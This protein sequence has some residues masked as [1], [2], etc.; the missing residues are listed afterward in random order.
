MKK[1]LSSIL[2]AV[3]TAGALLAQNYRSSDAAPYQPRDTWPY[4]YADFTSGVI[5]TT[6][7]AST[8]EGTFNVS[9]IDGSLHYIL[10]GTIMKLDMASVLTA[11]IGEELY[12]NIGNKMYRVLVEKEN[13]WLLQYEQVDMEEMNKASIGYGISSS[14]ASTQNVSTLLE[15]SSDM[16]NMLLENAISAKANG[17]VLPIAKSH[18]IYCGG[19][20]VAAARSSIREYPLI[21]KKEA[22]AF[23]KSHKIKWNKPESLE[24]LIDFVASQINKK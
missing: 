5:R 16:V 7:N 19:Y 3:L 11:K 2:L 23:L 9:L 10:N 22:D 13:G 8:T 18:H 20:L 24:Q 12:V 17:R 14:T 6:N 15:G 1:I 21:D 4:I